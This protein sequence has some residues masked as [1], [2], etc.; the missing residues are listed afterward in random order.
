MAGATGGTSMFIVSLA[1]TGEALVCSTIGASRGAGTSTF[2]S[3]FTCSRNGSP[4]NRFT[5]M[6]GR[7]IRF[8]SFEDTPT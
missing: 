7:C 4:S 6:G 3:V 1:G 5:A 2:G 8:G